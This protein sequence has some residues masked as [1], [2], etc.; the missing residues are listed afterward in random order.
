MILLEPAN[1]ITHSN[2]EIKR[3]TI[4]INGV[5]GNF[6]TNLPISGLLR[7][8]QIGSPRAPPKGTDHS[9]QPT[10]RY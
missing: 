3:R 7:R 9:T 5:I 4:S 6:E 8:L 2:V 10:Y 1:K